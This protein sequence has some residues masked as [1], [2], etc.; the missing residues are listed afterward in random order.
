MKRSVALTILLF[1]ICLFDA[2]IAQ[3][4]EVIN[5]VLERV[6]MIIA[7][8]E[9]YQPIGIGSGF[10]IG[11][12][13]EI[14]TNYHVIEGAS[15][16]IVKFVNK[17]EKYTVD[18]IVQTSTKYDLAIIQI[19]AKPAPLPLGDDELASVG[20]RIYAIGN[21]EG[22]EGTVSEGIISGFRKVD[23]NFR[24]MQI[25][26]PI[27]PGSSGGP[28]VNVNGQV[29]GLAS[30]SIILGQ[31]LNFAVPSKKLKEIFSK[32]S[33][34]VPF[35]KV[36]VPVDK[37]YKMSQQTKDTDLVTAFNVVRHSD[38]ARS[39]SFSIRNNSRRDVRN[40]KVLILWKSS[41]GEMLHFTP[42]LVKDIIPSLQTKMIQRG[43]MELIGLL[44]WPVKTEARIIDYEILKSSGLIEFK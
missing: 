8:D 35:E 33:K 44:P 26:A 31:N 36:N 42:I 32:P 18:N 22:L 30:A 16:A 6:V 39:M 29:I 20:S 14:A 2:K 38:S 23:E 7:M 5:T 37:D 27:S 25:T 19:S 4:N 43:Y 15:S 21:P 34:N 40:I 28:V 1:C 11:K 9:N 41:S 13:G 12:N 24:L 10:V 17:E 3:A